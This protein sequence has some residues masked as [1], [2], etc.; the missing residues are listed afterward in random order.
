M[1]RWTIDQIPDLTGKTAVITGANDGIG[2]ETALELA[3]RGCR[4]MMACRDTARAEAAKKKILQEAPN[5]DVLIEQLDLTDLDS[6]RTFATKLKS[7][8]SLSTLSL[9]VNNAGLNAYPHQ[10]TKNGYETIFQTNYLGHFLLTK[11]L[12]PLLIADGQARIV[13]VTSYFHHYGQNNFKAMSSQANQGYFKAYA[14]AK[15]E[16]LIFSVELEKRIR[17]ANLPLMSIAV[18]PGMVQTRILHHAPPQ[19][20][21]H[22]FFKLCE[23]LLAQPPKVGAMPTLYASTAPDAKGG[24]LYGPD[25]WFKPSGTPALE[26]PALAAKDTYL[27]DQLWDWSEELIG[28]KFVVGETPTQQARLAM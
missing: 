16:E 13:T 8:P 15:L 28:E 11:E 5:A 3:K 1:Q 6:I 7:N 25:G 19:D 22:R 17:S 24:E 20:L 23:P 21:L 18:H 26:N 9:L 14:N 2:Y 12:F 4:I 10:L 27:A